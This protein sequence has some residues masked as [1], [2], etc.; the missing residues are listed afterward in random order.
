METTWLDENLGS[1]ELRI[2]DCATLRSANPDPIDR[3]SYPVRPKSGRKSYDKGHIPGASFI[4][5]PNS[6]TDTSTHIP[7]MAPTQALALET[8][9]RAG[10]SKETSHVVL[11][12]STSQMWATRVWWI[13]RSLGFKKVSLLN[14]GWSKWVAEGRP[15]STRPTNYKPVIAQ[16]KYN[17][18]YFARKSEVI[19]ALGESD[20]LLIHALTPP[21]FEGSDDTLVFGRRGHIPGSVNIPSGSMF[22]SIDGT[23]LNPKDLAQWFE[24]EGADKARRIFIYCGGGINATVNA[25]SLSLLGYENVSVYD[26]SMNEWGNDHSLPIEQTLPA[27]TTSRV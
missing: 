16:G 4:D 22:D 26:G 11:Y 27:N 10:I 9:G 1:P 24:K 6:L 13:L 3:L 5:I 20:T 8:F 7:M 18:R 23:Y 19:S 15:I 2:F 17:E 25:F 21:V 14:G 12:S